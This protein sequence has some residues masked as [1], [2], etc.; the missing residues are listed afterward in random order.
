MKQ[1]L[2][3]VHRT[4]EYWRTCLRNAGREAV[5]RSRGYMTV[6]S[7]WWIHK[8]SGTPDSFA[9]GDATQRHLGLPS[10][11]GQEQHGVVVVDK[12]VGDS[13]HGMGF[14]PS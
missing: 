13:V 4:L 7:D 9:D 1:N 3:Q 11:R 14:L 12:F 2:W 8:L 5:G 6:S 10:H